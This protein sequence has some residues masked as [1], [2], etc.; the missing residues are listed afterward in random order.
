MRNPFV[1]G[2][3]VSGDNFCDRAREIKELVADIKNGQNVI[4]FSPRRYGK[5]SLIKQALRKVKAQG[6]LTFYIDLYPAISKRK[7]IEIYA[8][9]ISAGIPGGVRQV[10]K[11]IKEYLPRIIPKVVMD[12]QAFHL[13]FEFDR[14]GSI[15]P[16]IDDLLCAVNKEADRQNKSG[17]V[18]LDEFQEIANF[19]D[20]EIERKM[21]SVFQNH[22]NV[23]YIFMG[24][25][26][27]LMRDIFNNPNRPFYKSGKH[28]PLGKIDQK[29]L[30]LFAKKKFLNQDIVIGYNELNSILNNTECHPYYFQMLCNVLWELCMDSRM[31]TE[32]DIGKAL[33]ILI[34]RESSTY[35]AM[36]E[37]LTVKQKN[38]M[39]AL[40]K[41]E[42]PEVFSKKFLETYGLGPSSSIQK[43]LKKLLKK[44]LIQQENGSYIIYDLFFKKWIRRTW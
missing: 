20:D 19:D 16:N 38:L 36:W 7:F 29:E 37:E 42:C 32:A 1:Y 2:E 18:V 40:A 41:E 15:S 10:V 17:V 34:S 9:A 6:I 14:T 24:S 21:R 43:A 13:E 5:T 35:I 11:R 8:G 28:F 12:D 4:I 3:T 31:I 25:K 39:V 44:E 27:H 30:S 26:T 23:S 33:D 22:R